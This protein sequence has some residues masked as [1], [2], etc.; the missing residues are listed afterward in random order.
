[1]GGA[2]P[3]VGPNGDLWVAT[4]N[5]SVHY[6]HGFD[7]SDAVLEIS[8]SLRLLQFFAP[9]HWRI[10]NSDDLDMATEP[11][12]LPDGQV[13]LAGKSQVVYLLN[14][15]HLGGIGAQE[16][17]LSPVCATNMDGGG[18]DPGMIAYLPCLSGIIAVKAARS[19]PALHL[20]W[21]SNVGGGPPI[22]A[23]GLVWTI[24]Q[25]GNLYGLHPATGKIRQQAAIG[26]PANHFPT[27]G[28]GDG[29][30][31][32]AS[33]RNVI[34]FRTSAVSTSSAA[35]ATAARARVIAEVAL[36]CICLVAA[37]ALSWFIPG[38]R[39]RQFTRRS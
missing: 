34:A 20:L 28:I 32:A 14:G 9:A 38:R 26:R 13:I 39:R 4:G 33:A 11:I 22:M 21:S 3:A 8:P 37:G 27:P 19:P 10:D 30:M 5:G 23:G 31:L 1:M 7:G 29:Y 25:N 18:A 35:R 16:A 24:G 6:R 36:I 15:R 17:E 12:L 2:A